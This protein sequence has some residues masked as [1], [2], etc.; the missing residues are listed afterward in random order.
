MFEPDTKSTRHKHTLSAQ[1]RL[2][3]QTQNVL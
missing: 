3:K 1:T 2:I